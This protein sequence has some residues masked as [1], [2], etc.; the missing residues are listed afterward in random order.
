MS[1][2]DVVQ[3]SCCNKKIENA[4][5]WILSDFNNFTQRKLLVGKCSVCGDDAVLEIVRRVDTAKTYYNLYNGIE[6]VKV[7]YREKKRKITVIPDI[8]SDSLY[9]WVYGINT[10][11]RNK[12][13]EVTK[14]RQYASDFSGN[15]ELRKEFTT[16]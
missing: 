9:G 6:A 11:I 5:L 13:G 2:N 8:N 3:L 1:E 15:R 7:L 14:I 4:E 12:K 16:L 10:Q